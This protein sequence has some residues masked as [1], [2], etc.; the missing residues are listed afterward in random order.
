MVSSLCMR[1]STE[2]RAALG[3]RVVK[4]V[5][6]TQ[7]PRAGIAG[8]GVPA[9]A[10]LRFKG[11]TKSRGSLELLELQSAGPDLSA[12]VELHCPAGHRKVLGS[13]CHRASSASVVHLIFPGAKASVGLLMASQALHAALMS[14][15]VKTLQLPPPPPPSPPQQA[16]I[17]VELSSSSPAAGAPSSSRSSQPPPAVWVSGPRPN[18]FLLSVITQVEKPAGKKEPTTP[19]TVKLR[20]APFNVTEVCVHED[21]MRRG[22]LGCQDEV[23][24]G[25]SELEVAVEAAE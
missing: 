5:G 19:Y 3:V 10:G 14:G 17:L 4:E 22:G 23:E 16:W 24:V 20:G 15:A 25:V 18:H 6:G 2:A 11:E 7:Q 12:P 13:V 9:R 1:P 8:K 21:G